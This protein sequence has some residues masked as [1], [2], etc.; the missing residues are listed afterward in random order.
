MPKEG[1][2]ELDW[3]DSGVLFAIRLE[4]SRRQKTMLMW[5][6]ID[7]G[8]GMQ[9]EDSKGKKKQFDSGDL[10]MA[11]VCCQRFESESKSNFSAAVSLLLKSFSWWFGAEI[12]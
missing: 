4:S 9:E 1:L 2:T 10:Q 6:W 8:V 12:E 11:K 7:V 3:V 5:T